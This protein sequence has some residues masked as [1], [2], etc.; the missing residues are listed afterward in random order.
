[1]CGILGYVVAEGNSADTSFALEQAVSRLHH[2]GPDDSGVW[3]EGPVGLGFVRLA[4]IDLSP[5]G[6]QPMVSPDGRYVIVFNGEI[7]NF[8]DLRK[9]LEAAGE[10][11]V[12]HSDTEILL[13]LFLREGFEPCLTKLRGMFAFAVWDRR[14]QTL[15]IARDRL[16]VKPLV[17]A[18]TPRGLVFGSEIGSLFALDPAISRAADYTALDQYLTYQYVP[19]PLTGFADVRKLPPAHAMVVRQGRVDRIFRYWDMAAVP[20]TQLSF[21]DACAQL[22]ELILE[23][24]RIRMVAD[25]PLGAFLSGGVD[26]SI[27]V[28]AMARLSNRPVKTY[29]IGFGDEKFNELPF[30][31]QVA[32]HLGTEHHEQMCHPD[33]VD[34]L[35]KLIDNLGEPFADNSILP[36][37]YVSRFARGDVTVA[38]TGDGADE[39]FAGYRRHHHIWRV[40]TLDRLGLVPAW[41]RLR[42]FTVFLENRFSRHGGLRRFPHTQADQMLTLEGVE[43]FRHLIAYYPEADKAAL[44]TKVFHSRAGDTTLAPLNDAWQR[45]QTNPDVLNRWLYVDATTYLPNDILAK[46]DIASMAVS[47]ECRSPFLDHKVLEF[48]A[49]LPGSYKLTPRGRSKYILKEAFKD[50]LPPGFLERKKMGFSAPTPKWLREDLAPMM[51]EVLLGSPLL[52]EWFDRK[53]IAYFLDEHLSGRRSYSKRLW[54]LLCLAIWADRFGVTS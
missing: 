10:I 49:S 23:A 40:E 2:R 54:P 41:R 14:E 25:V 1:M 36:T 3:R 45:S 27:T 46:V 37:Y 7:Y 12:G 26:S 9:E 22:R 8:P 47:L 30:A 42:Q 34:L 29:A 17:Y 38:L 48:A 32:K 43:R 39:A 50:W 16:G 51:R 31:R 5:A 24:T 11:F 4:I 33:A 15:F 35:P 19:A 21:A 20:Q 53:T 13:R 18:E 44:A 52:G 28:A 6:H